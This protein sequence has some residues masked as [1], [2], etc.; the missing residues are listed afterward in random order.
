MAMMRNKRSRHPLGLGV[1]L[2][3]LSGVGLGVK[4]GAGEKL[5][6]KGAG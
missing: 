3:R 1:S 2:R 6:K 4:A 5:G